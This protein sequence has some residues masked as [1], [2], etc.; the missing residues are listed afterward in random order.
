MMKG[1]K[2]IDVFKGSLESYTRYYRKILM[3]QAG[4]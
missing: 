2:K 3:D 1:K 4:F